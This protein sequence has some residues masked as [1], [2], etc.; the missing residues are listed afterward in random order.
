VSRSSARREP[1][2]WTLSRLSAWRTVHRSGPDAATCRLATLD[3]ERSQMLSRRHGRHDTTGRPA[4]WPT[5]RRGELAVTRKVRGRLLGPTLDV[6]S[7]G[8]MKRPCPSA[9]ETGQPPSHD[10][11]SQPHAG[12][13]NRPWLG[14]VLPHPSPGRERSRRDRLASDSSCE[15]AWCLF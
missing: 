6:R 11:T 5:R 2:S 8:R 3:Q 12:E 1:T 10:S 14:P 15:V 7:I 9:T 13:G 4:V